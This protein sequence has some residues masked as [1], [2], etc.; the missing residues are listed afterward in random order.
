MTLEFET[1]VITFIVYCSYLFIGFK[2]VQLFV[3]L[4]GV[5]DRVMTELTTMPRDEILRK[6]KAVSQ[7]LEALRN[8]H[9]Q[10]LSNLQS[11]SA[12]SDAPSSD[13]KINAITKS[14]EQLELGVSEAQ[15]C[16]TYRYIF[17]CYCK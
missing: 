1:L 3:Q 17:H 9:Q 5:C 10:T 8:D 7:V 13:G 14:L 12:G 2:F 6:T 16:T 4:C 11:S 15:V